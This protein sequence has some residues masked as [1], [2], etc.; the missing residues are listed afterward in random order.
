MGTGLTPLR[1]GI[2]QAGTVSWCGCKHSGA[3]AH[4]DG[5]HKTLS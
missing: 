5:T 1:V 3:G 4:C 2:E